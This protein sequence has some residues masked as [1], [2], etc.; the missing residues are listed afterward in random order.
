MGRRNIRSSLGSKYSSMVICM[1]HRLCCTRAS[2]IVFQFVGPSQPLNKQDLVSSAMC[3]II[4][5]IYLP[6]GWST[7]S[8]NYC[9]NC[10]SS[11]RLPIPARLLATWLGG[12]LLMRLKT[13]FAITF[14]L[15][16]TGFACAIL[17]SV[18]CSCV[19]H[20][21]GKSIQRYFI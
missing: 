12:S 9:L 15:A 4:Y 8:K 5:L 2:R 6:N 20:K 18:M 7:L 13:E 14:M 19:Y 11:I 16:P 10:S 3:A 17:L 1:S 21:S